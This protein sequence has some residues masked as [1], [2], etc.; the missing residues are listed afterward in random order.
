MTVKHRSRCSCSGMSIVSGCGMFICICAHYYFSQ[1][2]NPHIVQLDIGHCAITRPMVIAWI[3]PNEDMLAT[4]VQHNS[5]TFSV[6]WHCQWFAIGI[7]NDSSSAVSSVLIGPCFGLGVASTVALP[8]RLGVG[9]T[10][11]HLCNTPF[12]LGS[13]PIR[14]TLL[15]YSV[16]IHNIEVVVHLCPIRAAV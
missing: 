8:A 14:L 16:T 1:W 13:A 6:V 2:C 11:W 9:H 3:R 7:C 12:A 4:A 15:S 10:S 5:D